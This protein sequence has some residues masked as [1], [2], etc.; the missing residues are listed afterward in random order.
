MTFYNNTPQQ[1]TPD[2]AAYTLKIFDAYT[3]TPIQVEVTVY[4]AVI[5]FFASRGF[6]D[7]AAKSISYAIIK[8]SLTKNFSPFQYLDT[9]KGYDNVQLSGI[10]A[11][12]INSARYKTSSVGTANPFV[13]R[14]YVSRNIA[15]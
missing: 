3:E 11:T 12:L 13:P 7:D 4:E 15:A 9:L 6:G 10:V 8:E 5:G 2:N 14:S 1:K